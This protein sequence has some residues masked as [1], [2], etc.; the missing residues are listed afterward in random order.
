MERHTDKRV[1]LWDLNGQTNPKLAAEWSKGLGG[2][3]N[4][5]L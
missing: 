4:E 2:L 1:W 5:T 3:G